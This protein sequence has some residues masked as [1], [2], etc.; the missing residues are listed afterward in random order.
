MCSCAYHFWKVRKLGRVMALYYIEIM[1][2]YHGCDYM[3]VGYTTTY[4]I[5]A[6][7]H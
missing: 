2:N 5:S 1:R 3:V 4:A 6:Y 7:N